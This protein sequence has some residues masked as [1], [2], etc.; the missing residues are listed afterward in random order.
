MNSN[1]DNFDWGCIS[2]VDKGFRLY[3]KNSDS[4][5]R[6]KNKKVS[7]KYRVVFDDGKKDKKYLKYILEEG[8]F[9]NIV[10]LYSFDI[11]DNE[12][13]DEWVIRDNNLKIK[14]YFENK[15][16]NFIMVDSVINKEFKDTDDTSKSEN[17]N[18][19]T[20]RVVNNSTKAERKRAFRKFV[21]E[22][23]VGTTRMDSLGWNYESKKFWKN[24]VLK[25]FNKNTDYN[26][27]KDEIDEILNES[28]VSYA[29]RQNIKISD[30][31]R[32]Y[33]KKEDC[34][35]FI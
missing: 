14:L 26:I 22:N 7:G 4:K 10:D 5:I 35:D 23:N 6:L 9:I 27:S 11:F 8:D 33:I 19:T 13:K 12:S 16:N 30:V 17:N 1:L 31:K 29:R 24:K 2:E 25:S 18:L 20:N 34:W 21:Y 28:K 32:F 15:K 3:K